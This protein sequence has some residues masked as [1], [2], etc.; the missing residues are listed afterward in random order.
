MIEEQDISINIT[1]ERA[2]LVFIFRDIARF[3]VLLP[4]L[5]Q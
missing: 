3:T 2:S 1:I 4:R 5:V